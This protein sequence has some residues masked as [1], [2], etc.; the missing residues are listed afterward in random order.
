MKCDYDD[1]DAVHLSAGVKRQPG[2]KA[3]RTLTKLEFYYLLFMLQ[4]WDM[5]SSSHCGSHM[6][7]CDV[8]FDFRHFKSYMRCC[9]L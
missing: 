8:K 5:E 1:D 9:P 7:D 4:Q 2:L 3:K 6:V